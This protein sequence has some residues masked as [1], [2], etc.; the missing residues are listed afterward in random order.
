MSMQVVLVVSDK[1]TVHFL[2]FNYLFRV[3]CVLIVD[4]DHDEHALVTCKRLEAVALT[5]RPRRHGAARPGGW[6]R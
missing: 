4:D 3:E 6:P 5:R 2:Y 1:S